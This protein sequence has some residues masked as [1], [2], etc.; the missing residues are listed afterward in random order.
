MVVLLWVHIP[1]SLNSICSVAHSGVFDRNVDA[2]EPML[3]SYDARISQ[4]NVRKMGF[5]IK[6]D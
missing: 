5:K 1:E 3:S 6:T 2:V 4:D